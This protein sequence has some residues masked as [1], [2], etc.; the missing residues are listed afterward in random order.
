MAG[1]R[2]PSWARGQTRVGAHLRVVM[3]DCG[4][5]LSS[6]SCGHARMECRSALHKAAR[7]SNGQP[8]RQTAKHDTGW[9]TQGVETAH[10]LSDATAQCDDAQV[11]QR[12]LVKELPNKHLHRT[13]GPSVPVWRAGSLAKAQS[14]KGSPFQAGR[15]RPGGSGILTG[16][17]PGA[18]QRRPCVTGGSRPRRRPATG[19]PPDSTAGEWWEHQWQRQR[20]QGRDE[21]S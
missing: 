7:R 13:R 9:P 15:T 12:V 21:A 2:E 19:P 6:V 20:G 3:W 11:A 4:L 5:P 10:P 17:P 18:L 14:N 16:A 1:G 8:K